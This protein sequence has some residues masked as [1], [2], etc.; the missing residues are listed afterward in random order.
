MAGRSPSGRWRPLLAC[1]YAVGRGM[2]LMLGPNRG[3]GMCRLQTREGPTHNLIATSN[4]RNTPHA[5]L[6]AAPASARACEQPRGAR[7]IRLGSA[8]GTGAAGGAVA[9]FFCRWAG[10]GGTLCCAVP[11]CAAPCCQTGCSFSVSAW[12]ASAL[13]APS[14]LLQTSSWT[15]CLPRCAAW[16]SPTTGRAGSSACPPCPT[17]SGEWEVGCVASNGGVRGSQGRLA[18][19]REVET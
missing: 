10:A 11:C 15:G 12:F 7:S 19:P 13:C 6:P 17:T 18:G 16:R 1:G 8:A 9:G 4:P 5:P 3:Q 2:L 14:R